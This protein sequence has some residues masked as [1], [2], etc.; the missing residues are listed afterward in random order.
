MLEFVHSAHELF[1]ST[2][3]FVFVGDVG[4]ATALFRRESP[5]AAIAAAHGGAVVPV[6]G[7]SNYGR[8]LSVFVDRWGNAVDRKTTVVILGDGRTNYHDPGEAALERIRANAR[9]LL[10]ICP[11]PRERW[12][13]GDS[14]MARYA[15]ICDDVFEVRSVRDLRSLPR[16]ATQG[17]SVGTPDT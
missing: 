12:A 6:T 16:G 4:E 14:A 1:E 10:W 11:E 3:S 7:N 8:A 2:R 9:T 5:D 15:E 13:E 17:A